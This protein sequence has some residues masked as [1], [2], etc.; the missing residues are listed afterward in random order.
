[1]KSN[2]IY[3]VLLYSNLGN[4]F[5]FLYLI[6]IARILNDNHFSLVTSLIALAT[7]IAYIFYFIVPFISDEISNKHTNDKI[8]FTYIDLIKKNI[9]LF[10]G[11]IFFFF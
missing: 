11:L 7:S 2:K 3:Q 10:L 6:L 5:S 8:K 1:M 4:F 9:I